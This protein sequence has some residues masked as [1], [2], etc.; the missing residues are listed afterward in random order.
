MASTPETKAK[1]EIQ[2]TIKEFC[3]THGLKA[4]LTWNAGA[5]YG[6][7]TVDCTGVIAG[8]AVAI[9]VKRFD[10]RGKL[11]ARQLADLR[12]FKEA[13]AVALLIDSKEALA[14]FVLF[15]SS[16]V[17]DSTVPAYRDWSN[18]P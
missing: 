4:K 15:L 10:G 8:V 3:K 2:D 11:T 18:I 12:E 6:S 13:G 5:A 7:A 9:E 1:R 17:V 14:H 16:R